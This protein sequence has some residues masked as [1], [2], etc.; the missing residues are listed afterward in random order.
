MFL[1]VILFAL[2]CFSGSGNAETQ[3]FVPQH[4]SMTQA[5]QIAVAHNPSVIQAGALVT[6][7]KEQLTQAK[8]GFFPQVSA[9]AGLSRTTS[10]L[11]AFGARLN[12][13][14][15][16]MEDFIP[17][18][19]NDPSATD[20][21]GLSLSAEWSL[22]DSGK[23]WYGTRQA[24]MGHAA[25]GFVL[26]RTTQE[27]IFSAVSAYNGVLLS[28]HHL[29]TIQ[30]ALKTAETNE[31]TVRARFESGFVVKSDLLQTRVHIA[32]LTQQRLQAESRMEVARAGLCAAMGVDPDSPFNLADT[33]HSD[34]EPGGTLD[35]WLETAR[36]NRP[37][38]KAVLQREAI[39]EAEVK[40]ARSSRLPSIALSAEYGTNADSFNDGKDSYTFGAVV[41]MNL[42]SGFRVSAKVA[43]A[44]A[45]LKQARAAHSGLEQKISIETRSAYHQARS[46]W[47]QIQVT[48][49]VVAQ[50][51]EA[52]RIVQDRYES[53]LLTI[54][55]LLNAELALQ[56]ARTNRYQ[57]IHDYN[58]AKTA[59]RLAAGTLNTDLND[60]PFSREEPKMWRKN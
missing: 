30:Q 41:C 49:T 48:D 58:I 29:E 55:E 59:L 54:V 11:W 32:N 14:V 16:G 23:T 56:Q 5:V 21:Y 50:A 47:Q 19:L 27:I 4:L 6:V 43:E 31:K 46:A 17:D 28:K 42:F 8:S 3:I 13:G 44:A 25:A 35:Q 51:E 22:Y 7:S 2:F 15:I 52:L 1:P 33:L 26:D 38:L 39:A 53:D 57:A 60:K 45:S 40:K 37:D 34:S 12:Q 10:P 18:R 36:T 20:N 9:S 24:R